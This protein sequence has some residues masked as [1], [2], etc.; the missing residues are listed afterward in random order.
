MA[1]SDGAQAMEDLVKIG[2]SGP[3]GEGETYTAQVT[4]ASKVVDI[5]QA[6]QQLAADKTAP[7][8]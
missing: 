4:A 1:T 2:G 8:K 7:P 3:L 5:A 6:A